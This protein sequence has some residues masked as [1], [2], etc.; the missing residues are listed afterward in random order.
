MDESYEPPLIEQR[1]VYG[2]HLQVRP[3]NVPVHHVG[4]ARSCYLIVSKALYISEMSPNQEWRDLN[5]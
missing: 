2:L 1:N 4:F 5:V 3:V